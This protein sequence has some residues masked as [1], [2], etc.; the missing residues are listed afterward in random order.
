LR[1][2]LIKQEMLNAIDQ[3]D[4]NWQRILAAQQRTIL[5]ARVLDVETR[6]FELGLRT[7][8]DVLDAQ[9]RLAN[10]QSSEIAAIT[11]YQIAQV[12]I[13]FA[14]GMLLGASNVS[15]EPT[16]APRF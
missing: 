3:L 13:A 14:A 6:Q 11:E 10:S 16:P 1:T 5:A 12:D 9:T 4:A 8:T 2:A 7:S 15:W